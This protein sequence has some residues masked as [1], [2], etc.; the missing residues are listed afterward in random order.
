MTTALEE[1]FAEAAKLPPQEQDAFAKWMLA[2]LNSEQ[3][4]TRL[5]NKSADQLAKLAEEALQEYRSGK[6][7]PLDPETL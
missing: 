4:W 7:Q 1:A 3:T 5:F 2:E 6:T